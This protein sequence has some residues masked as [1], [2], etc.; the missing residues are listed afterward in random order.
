MVQAS[1]EGVE[2]L[3]TYFGSYLPQ[4]FYSMLSPVTL[5]IVL[6][7]VSMKAAVVLLLCVPL[8]PVSIIAVQ[9]FAKK[10]LAKYWGQYTKMGDSFLENLQGLTTLKAVSYTH[11]DVYKRQSLFFSGVSRSTSL[12]DFPFLRL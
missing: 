8:I 5:F 7:F 6:S 3:E 2:Q 10:L 9:K 4:F 1:V 11:L 12:T